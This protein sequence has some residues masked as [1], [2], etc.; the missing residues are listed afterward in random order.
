MILR[1]L[2]LFTCA[3]TAAPVSFQRD[4][5]PLL[6]RRC[7]SCHGAEQAKG[8][9]RLDSF[10]RLMKPGE[11]DLL[12]IVAGKPQESELARL[13][14]EPS[15]EDR[16]PQK[17]DPLPEMEIALIE[18]WISEGASY[19]GGSPQRSLAELIRV[20]MLGAA[21]EKYARALPVVALAFSPDGSQVATSGYH[22]VL[23]WNVS[24]GS[25]AARLG[26][27]PER[28]NSVT[29]HPRLPLLAVAGGT[30]Q[31]WGTIALVD[32]TNLAPTRYLCDLPDTALSVA[33]S[34]SGS[35]LAAGGA[36]RAVRLYDPATG[37]ERKVLRLHADWV[38]A[39]TFSP[40]S[41]RLITA[42]RDRTSRILDP[43]SGEVLSSYT[44]HETPLVA[45]AFVGDGKQAWTA[46]RGGVMHRWDISSAERKGDAKGA[47]YLGLL[48]LRDGVLAWASDRKLRRFEGINLKSIWDGPDAFPQAAAL[49]PD[50]E[51]LALGTADGRVTLIAF[52][53]GN[54][55]RAFDAWPR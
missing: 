47:E 17:A 14:H 32:P 16:M 46:A 35:Y 26:A 34:P 51:T 29:W 33:F 36:D 21:P 44:S 43:G 4:L 27:L 20:T 12:T 25:L 49:S 40:D 24:D 52:T 3:A 15:A 18:R 45:A 5:A 6:Q 1:A 11:S 10:A 7:V 8:G 55:L 38:Q 42:S 13:L 19:D 37:R 53:D 31:Q 54:V 39:V 22:E 41:E 9:Y 50:G 48:P 30:P 23:V 2:A 28:I